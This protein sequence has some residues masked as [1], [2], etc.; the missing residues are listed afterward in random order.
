MTRVPTRSTPYTVESTG[1]D[2]FV[3]GRRIVAT[4]IDVVGLGG[5]YAVVS[6][7]TGSIHTAGPWNW[8]AD[9]SPTTSVLYALS[10]AAYFILMEVRFGQTVGK[11]LTGIRVIDE[12]TGATPGF[13][14]AS[15]RTVLRLVDG[16]AGYLVAYVVVLTSGRRRRLGDMA[17]HTLV[18]RA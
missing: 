11:M 3:T 14:P 17:A 5:A 8:V 7:G 6:A 1:T 13:G 15:I 9:T 4:L 2:V 10:V 18:V 16:L 12:A